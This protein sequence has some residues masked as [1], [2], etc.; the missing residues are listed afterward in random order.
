MSQIVP[1]QLLWLLCYALEKILTQYSEIISATK[2]KTVD[3]ATDIG[4]ET[5][6]NSYDLKV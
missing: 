6:L 5:T 3:F 4:I 2:F 1:R